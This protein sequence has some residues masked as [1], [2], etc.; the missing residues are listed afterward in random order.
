VQLLNK[1]S[2]EKRPHNRLRILL[3]DR[4]GKDLIALCTNGLE[5]IVKDK[6]R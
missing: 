1:K 3:M 6:G 4:V 5:E 2:Q